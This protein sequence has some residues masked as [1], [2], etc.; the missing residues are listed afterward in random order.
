M[1]KSLHYKH[2]FLS[3]GTLLAISLQGQQS[4]PIHADRS[5]DYEMA[6]EEDLYAMIL[7]NKDLYGHVDQDFSI[8]TDA[9]VSLLHTRYPELSYMIESTPTNILNQPEISDLLLQLLKEE[10]ANGI[11][12]QQSVAWHK[13]QDL[14]LNQQETA[15]LEFLYGYELF[16][17]KRFEQARQKLNRLGKLRKG[18]YEYALYYEGLSS[19]MLKDY[20]HAITS[21]KAIGK[22]KILIKHTPYYLA[23]AHYGLK[24][25]TLILKYY[26]PRI[27][28]NMLYNISGI[29]KIVAYA[30]YHLGHYQ[31]VIASMSVLQKYRSLSE[32]ELYILGKAHQSAGHEHQALEIL[33]QISEKP[34]SASIGQS[35]TLEYALNLSRAGHYDQAIR[36]YQKAIDQGTNNPNQVQYNIAVLLAKSGNYI[37]SAHQ[38][39]EL[40]HT[41]VAS[42]TR[43]LLTQYL[44]HIEDSDLYLQ[45]IDAIEGQEP[46]NHQI[47]TSLY[48]KALLALKSGNIEKAK[49]YFGKLSDLDPLIEKRG[50]VA[51]WMG[52]MA[53]HDK[54]YNK[55]KKYLHSFLKSQPPNIEDNTQNDRQLNFY[56]QYYLAYSY[57]KLKDH[58]KALGYYSKALTATINDVDIELLEDLHLRIADN[59][60][61]LNNY[62]QAIKA[63]LQAEQLNASHASYATWQRSVI[64]ELQNKPYDQ[65]L[66]LESIIDN[67]SQDPFYN[68]A[69]YSIA[70][71]LFALGKYDKASSFYIHLKE[72]DA[73]LPLKEKAT[74]QL[75]LISV[76]AGVYDKAKH[77]YNDILKTSDDPEIRRQAQIG[78]K[79]IYANFTGD[80]DAYIKVIKEE[81]NGNVPKVDSILFDL[82]IN[83]YELNKYEKAI[84]QWNKLLKEYPTSPLKIK[85]FYHLGLAQQKKKQFHQAMT[86][87]RKAIHANQQPWLGLAF[88]NLQSITIDSL[89]DDATFLQILSERKHL[90]PGFRPD[91]STLSK[92]INSAL[93]LKEHSMA[94][95]YFDQLYRDSD[96]PKSIK[97]KKLNELTQQFMVDKKWSLITKIYN[98]DAVSEYVLTQPKYIYYQS[99]SLMN[100]NKDSE[101]LT[102]IA[103]NYD[104]LLNDPAWLAKSIILMAD[105]YVLQKDTDS[106]IAALQ[107][108]V[109]TKSQVPPSLIKMAKNRLNLIKPNN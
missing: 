49:F 47:K 81:V 91:G 65:I 103:G 9:I 78:L 77:Y 67:S 94:I 100:Q 66:L 52:I 70:N 108:L 105:I 109:E 104:I 69:V 57:F 55:S 6:I 71:T 32:E 101:A 68:K 80:T 87:L 19:M 53:Y 26:A 10:T 50:A 96:L 24:D 15:T 41:S 48:Q 44:N 28:D 25:Y 45:V 17:K 30:Q 14:D 64:L 90:E 5:L 56:A 43:N 76:N 88:D 3:I 97:H 11:A 42:K 13:V 8:Q 85:S 23:A 92:A 107:A 60:F 39:L 73:P 86:S 27:D 82:A 59:Y 62:N 102:N 99:L 72:S 2:L 16:K 37:E 58:K 83:N 84:E 93:R 79:E 74:I 38:A 34:Q 40:L 46:N 33:A 95:Q 20:T 12:D 106:A 31:D 89:N 22:N 98:L 21:L 54:K 75:G 1:C 18:P 7:S 29:C 36:S 61:L 35:A 63:Y 4:S 51:G